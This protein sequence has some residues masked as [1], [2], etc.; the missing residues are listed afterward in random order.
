MSRSSFDEYM[1]K[2]IPGLEQDFT[3]ALH[4]LEATRPDDPRSF[5][6]NHLLKLSQDEQPDLSAL[7][8]DSAL[9]KLRDR[10]LKA[11]E[12]VRSSQVAQTDSRGSS[13]PE[14]LKNFT[15]LA[16]DPEVQ[17][18]SEGLHALELAVVRDP[19]SGE[20]ISELR[21][22]LTSLAE[23]AA[24]TSTR[25]R[26]THDARTRTGDAA[27]DFRAHA[28]GGLHRACGR[29]PDRHLLSASR[30]SNTRFA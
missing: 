21:R 24:Y 4:L 28:E 19:S 6:A 30:S 8:N 2:H 7:A 22:A 11:L 26:K 25:A 18:A 10:T 15:P 12:S 14:G 16:D 1:E 13:L 17:G 27:K 5:V 3:D 9:G 29:V 23:V 20:T